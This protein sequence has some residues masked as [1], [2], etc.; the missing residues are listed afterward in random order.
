MRRFWAPRSPC[1]TLAGTVQ[2]T[3]PKHSEAGRRMRLRGRGI[4]SHGGSAAG[5]LYATLK[6]VV[7]GVPDAALEAAM[8]AWGEA[9]RADPRAA[10]LASVEDF[11]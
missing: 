8:Q 2:L 10:L 1:P 11:A 6:L 9:A 5:D 7:G 4:P 3:I